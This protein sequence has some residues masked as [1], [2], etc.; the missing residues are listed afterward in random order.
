MTDVKFYYIAILNHLGVIKERAQAHLKI[1]S[2][3]C[4]YKSCLFNI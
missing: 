4:V 2:T 3:K 1:L